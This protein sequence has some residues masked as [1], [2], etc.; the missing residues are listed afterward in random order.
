MVMIEV[1]IDSIRVSLVSPQR[2]IILKD[3]DRERFL[4]IWIGPLEA[5]SITIKLQNIEVKRPLTHDL[6]NTLISEFGAIVS[7]VLV[8]ELRNDTY[9]AR[10]VLDVNGEH[11]EIDSRPSDSIALAVR[12][13]VPIFVSEEVMEQASIIPE[14]DQEKGGGADLSAFR[15]FVN[16]LDLEEIDP[17]E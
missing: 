3:V 6:L 7:H 4:P 12:A 15:D 16:T 14:Q 10:I 5:E 9:Y 8:H 2:L 1:T 13:Q 11:K 17:D